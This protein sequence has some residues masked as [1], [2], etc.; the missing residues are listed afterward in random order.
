MNCMTQLCFKK[1]RRWYNLAATEAFNHALEN[2]SLLYVGD[3]QW[4]PNLALRIST[5]IKQM[6]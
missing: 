5:Q 2:N 1:V 4:T 6:L 3:L